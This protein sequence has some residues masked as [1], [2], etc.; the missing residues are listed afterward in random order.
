[1]FCRRRARRL[2]LLLSLTMLSQQPAPLA[3][4]TRFRPLAP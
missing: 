1:M 4:A 2:M 3:R